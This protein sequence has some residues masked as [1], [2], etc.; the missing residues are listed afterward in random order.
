MSH[1][2]TIRLAERRDV[3]ALMAIE[4]SQF[5]EPWSRAMLLDEL[6]NVATRRYTV[7]LEDGRVLGYLGVMF[8]MDELHINTLA[9]TKADQGRGVASSLLEE[10][11]I[12]ARARGITRATLEVAVSNT[13]AQQLYFRYGFAPVGVRKNYYARTNEDALVLWA[14]IETDD[15]EPER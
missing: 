2:W 7:A 12:D 9:T 5:P 6:V 15:R 11:W 8:V 14:A 3:G 1:P 10:A 4:E 13:R